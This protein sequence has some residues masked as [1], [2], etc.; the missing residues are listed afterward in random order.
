MLVSSW[1]GGT[2]LYFNS[3][4][5]GVWYSNSNNTN[6]SYP[7]IDIPENLNAEDYE[8]FQVIKKIISYS[9]LYVNIFIL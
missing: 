3:N 6:S 8:V 4:H 2:D 1:C 5:G 7:K 9:I